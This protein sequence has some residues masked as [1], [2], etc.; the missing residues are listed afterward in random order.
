[1]LYFGCWNEAG[2]HL[3]DSTGRSY[4]AH[5]RS[6]LS[7]KDLDGV[8]APRG[9]NERED[10][11][12]LV[13]IHKWT[14]L[15]MWDRSVDK[16][17]ASN[18]AF[19]EEGTHDEAEMWRRARVAFPRV[20]ARLKAA[21]KVDAVDPQAGSTGKPSTRENTSELAPDAAQPSPD[22]TETR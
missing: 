2:H 22:T 19:L 3:R 5:E 18:A 14:V 13:H 4:Y 16:R 12:E 10:V 20:V 1:M 21:P 7:A 9:V 8:F 11:T 17:G 6:P 15:A